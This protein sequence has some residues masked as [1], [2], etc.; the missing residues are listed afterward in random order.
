MYCT[1]YK[2]GQSPEQNK[3]LVVAGGHENCVFSQGIGDFNITYA[4]LSEEL[5]PAPLARRTLGY[6]SVASVSSSSLRRI[7]E[8]QIEF[9]PSLVR[10]PVIVTS[11]PGFRVSLLHPV[12]TR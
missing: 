12:R 6:Q 5:A 3:T 9:E 8:I 10:Y 2:T 4:C 11:S 1:I 7:L